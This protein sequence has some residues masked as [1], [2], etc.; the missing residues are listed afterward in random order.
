[1]RGLLHRFILSFIMLISWAISKPCYSED[2]SPI[3]I[4]FVGDIMLDNGPGHLI[5]NGVDP[6]E[7]CAA[8]LDKPD[9]TIGN[10]ECVVGREGEQLNKAYT[11]RAAGDSPRY[12]KKYFDAVSIANN[13]TFDYGEEG[14]RESLRVLKREGIAFF[15]GGNNLAEARAPLILECKGK[16]IALLGY[17]EFRASNYAATSSTAGNAPLDEL[18]VVTDIRAARSDHHC[19][20][21][22]PFVH[23]GEELYSAPRPDQRKLARRWVDA[24]ATAVI[25]AHPHVSQTLDFYRGAPIVYSLG[26]FVFDYYPGDPLVWSGWCVELSIS[27]TGTV[28]IE[29]TVVELDTTGVPRIVVPE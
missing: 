20:I 22:I 19:D 8:L 10:L 13:H 9:L 3:R 21:V 28:E 27:P 12:I 24:G 7:A 16:K 26:N 14:F 18:S 4:L 25:G 11:F 1:M 17:N 2:A 29:T 23:W 5:S 15:G 6:F